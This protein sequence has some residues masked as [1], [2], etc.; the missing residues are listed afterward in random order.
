MSW[1]SRKYLAISYKRRKGFLTD[2]GNCV[3]VDRLWIT[4]II[5]QLAVRCYR[6]VLLYSKGKEI[7]TFF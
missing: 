7:T 2:M 1:I 6:A 4:A 5:L 3:P